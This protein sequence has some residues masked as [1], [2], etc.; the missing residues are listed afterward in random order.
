MPWAAIIARHDMVRDLCDNGWIAL[1]ACDDDGTVTHR[2]AGG[3]NWTE[4][5]P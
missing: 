2:Y 4:I 3:S 1:Y 5:G